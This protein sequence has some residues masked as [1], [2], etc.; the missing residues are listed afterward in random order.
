MKNILKKQEE[1]KSIQL[2]YFTIEEVRQSLSRKLNYVSDYRLVRDD[3]NWDL[4]AA[5]MKT[6]N[7]RQ[8]LQ[9]W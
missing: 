9:Q 8:C 1:P 3:I 2:K 5:K 7:E 6:R 4:I